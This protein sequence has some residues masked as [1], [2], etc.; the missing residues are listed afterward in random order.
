[1]NMDGGKVH[2]TQKPVDL[3]KWCISQIPDMAPGATILD[4]FM[5]S[6]STGVAALKL[7]YKFIGIEQNKDHYET[8]IKRITEAVGQG[9]GLFNL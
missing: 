1:M 4:P 2:P 5:G 3:M 8:C 6:S 7:G 9:G